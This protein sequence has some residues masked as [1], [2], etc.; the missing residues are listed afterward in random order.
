MSKKVGRPLIAIDWVDFDKLCQLQC[1]QREIASWFD[2]SEDTIERACLRDQK[3]AF[4]EYFEQKRGRG[5][6]ALRR[7]QYE[8]AMSG[9]P[10]MLIWLGKQYLGQSDKQVVEQTTNIHEEKLVIDLTGSESKSNDH[11]SSN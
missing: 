2:C 11:E 5:K 6:I 7:K 3:M 8:L 4:A 9:S 1:T 10:V